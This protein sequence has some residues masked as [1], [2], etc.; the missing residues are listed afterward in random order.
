[1]TWLIHNF[2]ATRQASAP[3]QSARYIDENFRFWVIFK[4]YLKLIVFWRFLRNIFQHLC[5]FFF[6]QNNR[7]S[8]RWSLVAKMGRFAFGTFRL[9]LVD[10]NYSI[11]NYVKFRANLS[12]WCWFEPWNSK[13]HHKYH[14]NS[15]T[16]WKFQICN[17]I[18]FHGTTLLPW[19]VGV[20]LGRRLSVCLAWT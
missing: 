7:T 2:L 18:R 13:F 10:E 9:H 14:R 8:A 6:C 4:K 1:M 16:N 3:W 15:I 19:T 17:L 20:S 12:F 11:K 5:R